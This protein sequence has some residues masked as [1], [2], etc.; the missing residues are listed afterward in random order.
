MKHISVIKDW[1]KPIDPYLKLLINLALHHCWIASDNQIEIKVSSAMFFPLCLWGLHFWRTHVVHFRYVIHCLGRSQW[2]RAWKQWEREG[3]CYTF[4][5]IW[6]HGVETTCFLFA[7]RFS[8]KAT[9][10]WLQLFEGS[11]VPYGPI[12]NMQQVFSDPQVG[13]HQVFSIRYYMCFTNA[14]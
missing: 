3:T 12:N 5:K 13:S 9:M 8:E 1:R 7:L 2:G 11:G 4:F 10:E 6:K 14:A